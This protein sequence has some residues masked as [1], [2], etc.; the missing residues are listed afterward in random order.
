MHARGP[1]AWERFVLPAF[2]LSWLVLIYIA[3]FHPPIYT[4]PMQVTW[5]GPSAVIVVS[6]PPELQRAGVQPGTVIDSLSFANATRLRGTTAKGL[7][8]MI[9]VRHGGSIHYVTTHADTPLTDEFPAQMWFEFFT[10]TFSMLLAGYLGYRRPGIMI[11][12]LILFIG[13]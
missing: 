5:Y 8:M 11:A 2:S 10:L 9:P 12:A 4:P 6:A 7:Q 1:F 3:L 13:G